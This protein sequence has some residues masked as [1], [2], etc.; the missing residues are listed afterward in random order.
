MINL[1]KAVAQYVEAANAKDAQGVAAVFLPDATVHD[2]G[3]LRRG[4]DEIAAWADE[5]GH[6]YGM[7][8]APHSIEGTDGRRTMHAEVSGN[9]PGSPTTL[10]FHFELQ[11]DAIAALEIKP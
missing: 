8:I 6:K 7:T 9:F 4:R 1:P 11:A 2:E 3:R 5:T 10:A